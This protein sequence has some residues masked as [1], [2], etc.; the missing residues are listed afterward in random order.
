MKT[1]S[2]PPRPTIFLRLPVK[3]RGWTWAHRISQVIFLALLLLSRHLDF[4]WLTGSTAA[5]KLLGFLHL[6]DP[7]GAIEIMLASRSFPAALWLSAGILL[8]IYAILGRTFCSWIC[9][10]GLVLDITEDVRR[11]FVSKSTGKRMSGK[12]KYVLLGI[13]LVLSLLSGIPTFTLISPINIL[14]RNIVFGFGPEILLVLIIIAIDL[15]Y[16]RRA[17]CRYLC[18]L[19]AF[20]SLLGRFAFL[21][22]RIK[23]QGTSCTT[24]GSCIQNCPMGINLLKDDVLKGHRMIND[25]ECTRCGT[26]IEDCNGGTLHLGFAKPT[27]N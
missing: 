25:P 22:I 19:G 1:T 4:N 7:F 2:P 21:H 20:Y 11:R 26:C 17:W 13:F 14:S 24:C 6:V 12:I 8:I 3:I 16:S 23:D 15:F 5:T 27:K 10:L 9:P 18:P